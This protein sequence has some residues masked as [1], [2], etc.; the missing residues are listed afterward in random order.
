MFAGQ[1][2]RSH[3]SVPGRWARVLVT[4]PAA[5]RQERVKVPARVP[6]GTN[7]DYLAGSGGFS[8]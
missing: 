1:S 4:A 8:E 7:K 6:S 3:S 5:T 2:D